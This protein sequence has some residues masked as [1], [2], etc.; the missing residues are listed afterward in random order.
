MQF[1]IVFPVVFIQVFLI[2]LLE[3]MKI[4]RA[5]RINTFV[6]NKVFAILFV[7]E[8]VVAMRTAK[9][10]RFRETIIFSW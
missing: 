2:N 7:D 6:N 10:S 9:D 5:F 3:I 4:V 8:V 1:I